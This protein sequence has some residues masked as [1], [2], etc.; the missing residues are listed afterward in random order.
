MIAY[1]DLVEA[2]HTRKWHVREYLSAEEERRALPEEYSQQLS[3]EARTARAAIWRIAESSSFLLSAEVMQAVEIMQR[4][5]NQA[6]TQKTWH[7]ILDEEY[8]AINACLIEVN[9][10]GPKNWAS[11]AVEP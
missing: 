10:L 9:A 11:N 8:D 3:Q 5:L 6:R 7:S 4:K 2:L 1:S